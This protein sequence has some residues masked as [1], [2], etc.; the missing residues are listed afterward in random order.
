MYFCRDIEPSERSAAIPPFLAMEILDQ[1]KKLEAQGR[2]IVHLELGEPDFPPPDNVVEAALL[3]IKKGYTSYTPTQGILELRQAVSEHYKLEYSC[4][5]DPDRIIVTM[6]S[7]PGMLLVFGV[8][9]NPGDEIIIPVPH[10]PPY[11]HNIRFI[12]GN[13]L[14]FEL[15]EDEGF[16]YDVDRVAKKITMRTKGIILNSPSNPTGMLQSES[17]HRELADLADKSGV[18]VISDEI[19]HGLTYGGKSRSILE[20][21]D[22]A[23]VLS[24]FSKRYA[25]T[26][27]RLGWIIAP[28]KFIPAMKNLH[29]N[30]FLSA[31]SFVQVAGIEALTHC[32]DA[33]EKMRA[34]YQMRRDFLIPELRGMGFGLAREPDGAFYLLLNAKNFTGDSL[35]F[36]RTLLHEAG[37]ALTPGVDF[38]PEAEGYVRISYAT[39]MP[40]L[41]EAVDRMKRWISA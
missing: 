21:T 39:A 38:G 10:Y 26:G 37:V 24:G 13:P 7:S 31:S 25:M 22:Q 14:K 23:F 41:T 27:W 28:E 36:S 33:T 40:Q 30:Y 29:M 17:V 18:Y 19:Y 16:Q 11:P 3:G 1:A 6:G 2:D 32:Q 8:L 5:I 15:S 12:G 34:T 9:L 4:E 35:E 20:F